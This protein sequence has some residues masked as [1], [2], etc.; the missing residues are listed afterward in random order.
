M[1]EFLEFIQDLGRRALEMASYC[2]QKNCDYD[3][4]QS[5]LDRWRAYLHGCRSTRWS[6]LEKA[7]EIAIKE[8]EDAESRFEMLHLDTEKVIEMAI[9]QRDDAERRCQALQ[10]STSLQEGHLQPMAVALKFELDFE[11]MFHDASSLMSFSSQLQED[12]CHSLK[13]PRATVHVL[14]FKKG[15]MMSWAEILLNKVVDHSYP[16]S[17]YPRTP[18]DVADELVQQTCDRKSVF[19]RTSIGSLARSAELHGAVTSHVCVA[20]EKSLHL[21][22]SKACIRK[23]WFS[24]LKCLGGGLVGTSQSSFRD[25]HKPHVQPPR[26]M[27]GTSGPSTAVLDPNTTPNT[28][29][30]MP[31]LEMSS[32][33]KT[34]TPQHKK[35]PAQVQN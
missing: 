35:I 30:A 8:R 24:S 28:Q 32:R 13:I 12:L 18:K 10:L 11:E 25:V 23:H 4:L 34:A 7:V 26:L 1:S 14:C 15:S 19:R 27:R 2:E 9:I 17:G 31:K 3:S 29:I 16:G 20:V 22:L 5:V 6:V 33:R 21:L